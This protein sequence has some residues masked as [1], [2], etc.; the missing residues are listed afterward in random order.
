MKILRLLATACIILF[1]SG[2]DGTQQ[3]EKEEATDIPITTKSDQALNT[4]NE[5]RTLMDLGKII[6]ANQMFEKSL[7]YDPDF[8]LGYVNAAN[9]SAS[10]MELNQHLEKAKQSESEISEGEQIL[11]QISETFLTN[12]T[13][14][15][16]ELAKKLTE[17]YPESPRAWTTLGSVYASQKLNEE[18]RRATANALELDPDFLLAN[19]QL[20]F[21]YLFNE[22]KDLSKAEAHMKDAISIFPEEATLYVNL[23]DVY[24]GQQEL[25]MAL[26]A[27][28]KAVE[29][30]PDNTVAKVKQ[31]H[32][33][34]F[35]GNYE[36]ARANYDAALNQA[37][38]VNYGGFANFKAFTHL[39]EGNPNAAVE[40]LEANLE[41][42]DGLDI[43]ESEKLGNKIQ[44]TTNI[45][46]I[47]LHHGM[48]D[49][50][51][52][53][54]ENLEALRRQQMDII[55]NPMFVANQEALIAYWNGLE[56]AKKGDYDEAKLLAAENR[57]FVENV[58]NP[59]KYQDSEHLLGV[60][61][62]WQGNYELAIEHL[63]EGSLDNDVHVKYQLALAQE[64]AGNDAIA[65]ELFKEVATWN[66]NSVNFALV[67][68]AAM[69]KMQ[70]A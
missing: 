55:D 5:A 47:Q 40:E 13:E 2:C 12:N 32:V 67:R 49:D 63:K 48:L 3:K 56:A 9:T 24:R 35:L 50:L 68:G 52:G 53:T 36:D 33:N 31:G 16:L 65:Q 29:M 22:P 6:D 45:A 57:E 1:L 20:G 19:T 34:S 14:E 66:F 18:A 15:R 43:T 4:F 39:Y 25:E 17:I 38:P 46:S 62:L 54:V 23:G 44:T 11:L 41:T 58:K 51:T 21:S 27:Y 69:E 64:G 26:N 10:V 60:I 37:D 28:T 61:E 7:E 42:I 30:D 8:V 70:S 59:L